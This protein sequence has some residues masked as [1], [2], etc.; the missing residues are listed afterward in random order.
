MIEITG[1][2]MESLDWLWWLILLLLLIP[3]RIYGRWFALAIGGAIWAV[4]KMEKEAEEGAYQ[5]EAE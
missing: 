3:I 2:E 5:S 4:W 1:D